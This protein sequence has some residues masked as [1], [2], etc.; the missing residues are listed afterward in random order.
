MVEMVVNTE[1]AGRYMFLEMITE[2]LLEQAI[3]E[4]AFH[5]LEIIMTQNLES[6]SL[7]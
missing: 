7:L 1:M 3:L 6:R 5:I 2:E 4:M